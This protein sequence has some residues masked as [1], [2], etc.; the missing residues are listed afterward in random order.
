MISVVIGKV[1]SVEV[2]LQVR[3]PVNNERSCFH[4]VVREEEDRR[5]CHLPQN[6]TIKR[7]GRGFV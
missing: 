2:D 4:I 6:E 3:G 5:K 7:V 1:F